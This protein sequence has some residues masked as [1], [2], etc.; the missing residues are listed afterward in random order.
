[1]FSRTGNKK[2]SKHPHDEEG[3]RDHSSSDE[4]GGP[5]TVYAVTAVS[6]RTRAPQLALKN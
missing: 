2:S 5:A 1:M 3:A 4:A 6:A